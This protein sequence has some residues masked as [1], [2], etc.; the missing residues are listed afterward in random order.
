MSKMKAIKVYFGTPERPVTFEELKAL[1]TEER[2]EL[3][4]GAAKELGVNLTVL[5]QKEAT[6]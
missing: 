3:A 5:K 1:S 6:P 2:E 4:R